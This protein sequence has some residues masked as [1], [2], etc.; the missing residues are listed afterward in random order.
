MRLTDLFRRPGTAPATPRA[1]VVGFFSTAGDVGSLDVVRGWLEAEALAY[2]VAPFARRVA[3]E[4]PGTLD[5]RRVDPSS[6][7]HL[8]V[9]CGPC[10]EAEL[11]RNR[12]TRARFGHCRWIGVNLTMIAPLSDWNPFDALLERDSDRVENAD[13][14]FLADPP[15]MQGLAG[16]CLVGKQV[17]YGDRQQLAAVGRAFR[18]AAARHGLAAIDID[19]RW[20]LVR[21]RSGLDGPAALISAMARCDVVLTNRLHGMVYAL[22]AGTPPVAIDGIS[23]GAKVMAQARAIGWTLAAPA[24]IADDKW[25]DRA[26]DE[27]LAPGARDAARDAATRARA[28]LQPLKGLFSQALGPR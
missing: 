19:T 21:N 24:D 2:D 3:A 5:Q 15:A 16:L 12:I 18:A 4:F 8:I 6:Y 10:W 22:K 13:L 17:E 23:G 25:L 9:V 1:L 20:P 7:S 14:A 11:R 27:A 26:L 28:G